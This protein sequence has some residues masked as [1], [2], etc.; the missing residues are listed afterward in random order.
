MI[1]SRRAHDLSVERPNAFSA[2]RHR[3]YK[4]YWF[5][6]CASTIGT[7]MQTVGQSWLVLELTDSPFLL[8]LESAVQYLPA[9]VLSL[10]AGCIADHVSKRRILV[11]AQ[12]AM[13]ICAFVL[14]ALT[15]M[16]RVRFW[17]V[18]ALS[19]ISGCA[20]AFDIPTRQSLMI[21]LVGRE[22]LMSAIS[23]NS[24]LFNVARTVGPA[25]AG[26]VLARY[27]A[28]TAF[29]LNGISFLAII[30]ALLMM[31]S[32][33]VT[34]VHGQDEWY[35]RLRDD[36]LEGVRFVASTPVALFVVVA[37]FLV[38]VFA[39]NYQVL[40]PVIAKQVL[41][42]GASGYGL[43]MSALGVGA[44]V[45]ALTM[46]YLSYRGPRPSMVMA[47]AFAAPLALTAL[48]FASSL[49]TAM[50]FMAVYGW[51]MIAFVSHANSLLQ[52]N[53]P[54]HLRGRVMGVYSVVLLGSAPAGAIY[55]GAV[56]GA[57]GGRAGCL[58]AALGGFVS[59]IMLVLWVHRR[60]VFSGPDSNGFLPPSTPEVV[61]PRQGHTDNLAG[62]HG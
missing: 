4:L 43:L 35:R 44:L 33:A 1:I 11:I 54:D 13:M 17:H 19:F 14:S 23:L 32:P 2:F 22:D 42:E 47:G 59:A 28:A 6:M 31:R 49:T 48:G 3:D 29:L 53:T 37:L 16:G 8:G 15:Y 40:A 52:Y 20:T 62:G 9:V 5:G 12:S 26:L 61:R 60:H 57:L 36:I 30:L 38:S 55:V 56:S 18:A 24:A 25:L 50:A 41:G 27:S 51:W 7:W 34:M 58:A 39:F 10:P 21:Q 45:A 46:S